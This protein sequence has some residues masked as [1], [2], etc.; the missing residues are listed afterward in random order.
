[1]KTASLTHYGTKCKLAQLL[2]DHIGKLTIST[3]A[4]HRHTLCQH[5][6][7]DIHNK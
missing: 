3:E 1:M 5:P 6:D 2:W 7:K 4:E